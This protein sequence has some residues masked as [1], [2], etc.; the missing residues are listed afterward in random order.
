MHTNLLRHS[1]DLQRKGQHHYRH[2]NPRKHNARV[3]L[4]D[5]FT[6]IFNWNIDNNN[7]QKTNEN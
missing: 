6:P 7:L 3:S 5:N 1:E 2:P 4:L